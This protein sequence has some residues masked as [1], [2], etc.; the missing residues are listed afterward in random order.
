MKKATSTAGTIETAVRVVDLGNAAAQ[1]QL[2]AVLLESCLTGALRLAHERYLVL[3]QVVGLHD[4]CQILSDLG[5]CGFSRPAFSKVRVIE[6]LLDLQALLVIHALGGSGL[7]TA[8]F[9]CQLFDGCV[10]CRQVGRV[11]LQLA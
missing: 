1:I 9:Q 10:D 5:A 7:L 8:L 6:L 4:A 3:Q 2:D 11:Q